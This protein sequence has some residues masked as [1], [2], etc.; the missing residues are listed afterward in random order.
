KSAGSVID[1]KEKQNAGE[2]IETKRM[3]VANASTG[4]EFVGQS[5]RFNDQQ[6]DGGEKFRVPVQERIKNIDNHV[7]ERAPIIDRRL[8][9]LCAMRTGQFAAAILTMRKRQRLSI[10]APPEPASACSSLGR[11]DRGIAK[12]DFCGFVG[13][14]GPR[15]RKRRAVR[16]SQKEQANCPDG[17]DC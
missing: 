17:T 9:A 6:A 14:G 3:K 15:L 2:Q 16:L 8:P 1:G 10:F 12:D 13:H 5:P 4:K 7:P 11:R